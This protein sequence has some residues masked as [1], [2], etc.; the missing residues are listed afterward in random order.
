MTKQQICI[1][2]VLLVVLFALIYSLNFYFLTQLNDEL[3]LARERDRTPQKLEQQIR[4]ATRNL[5][6]QYV[7]KNPRFYTVRN[8][9][10]HNLSPMRYENASILW[11]ISHYVSKYQH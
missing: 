8:K 9:L 1:V 6:P 4:R 11:D 2:F 3:L 10:L 7:N 5:K